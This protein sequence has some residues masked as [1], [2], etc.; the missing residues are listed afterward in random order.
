MHLIVCISGTMSVKVFNNR[1]V[2]Q[3]VIGTARTPPRQAANRRRGCLI[4]RDLR[5][6]WGTE[7]TERKELLWRRLA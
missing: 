7:E 4:K 6:L 5:N 2:M 1:Q 3:V